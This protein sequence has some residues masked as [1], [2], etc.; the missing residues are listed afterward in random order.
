M[1]SKAVSISRTL[2]AHGEEVGRLVATELAFRYVDN[3]IINQAAERAGVSPEAVA[4]NE[5]T[6]PLLTRIL[7]AIAKAPVE[8]DMMV[9]QATHPVNLTSAYEDLIEQVIVETAQQGGV[10][11][12]AH[13]AS[14]PLA[15]VPGVLRVL[16]T[17][18]ASTRIERVAAEQDLAE[19]QA[20]ETVEESD[21]ERERYFERIYE[22]NRELPTHY[23]LVV[24]TDVLTA[25]NA[26][27]IISH[28]A[29]AA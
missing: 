8:P 6:Q 17:A 20:K 21:K 10:V 22:L 9:A 28:A 7:D 5:K 3:E 14:I 18:S 19:K 29:T 12:L 26:A 23:D 11:I 16:V 24:N 25:E 4:S 2:G 15:K 1:S 13:G 27:Q